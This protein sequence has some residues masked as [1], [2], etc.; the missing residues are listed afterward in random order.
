MLIKIETKNM[1]FP[2]QSYQGSRIS[3]WIA[4]IETAELCEFIVIQ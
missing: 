4:I 1:H 2:Q 3:W